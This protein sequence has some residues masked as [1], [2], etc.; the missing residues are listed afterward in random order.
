MHGEGMRENKCTVLDLGLYRFLTSLIMSDM[1][2][3]S[4]ISRKSATLKQGGDDE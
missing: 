1:N 4:A 3:H 2:W